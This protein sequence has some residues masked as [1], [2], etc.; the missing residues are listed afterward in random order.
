MYVYTHV[1][2]EDCVFII[3]KDAIIDKLKKIFDV[4]GNIENNLSFHFCM[5]L[6]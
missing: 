2:F 1:G 3:M 6:R 5:V 4:F